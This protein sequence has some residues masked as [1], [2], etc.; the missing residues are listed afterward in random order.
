MENLVQILSNK[1]H[2]IVSIIQD[3]EIIIKFNY[4][5]K[6]NTLFNNINLEKYILI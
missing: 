2:F 4:F 6:I 5:H 1:M 3:N